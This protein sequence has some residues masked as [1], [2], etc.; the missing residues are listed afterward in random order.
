MSGQGTFLRHRERLDLGAVRGVF[1]IRLASAVMEL[2]IYLPN[3]GASGTDDAK[4]WCY[5]NMELQV[6]A[7]F[8]GIVCVV[9]VW[10]PL[11]A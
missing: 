10:L 9:Y 5:P 8:V 3:C 2:S 1:R 6:G 4:R 7:L 11:W